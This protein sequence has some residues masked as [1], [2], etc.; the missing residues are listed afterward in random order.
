MK[1]YAAVV[2]SSEYFYLSVGMFLNVFG[3]FG[4]FNCKYYD[5]MSLCFLFP[6]IQYYFHLYKMLDARRSVRSNHPTSKQGK[7]LKPKHSH[8]RVFA[9]P[10]DLDSLVSPSICPF[11]ALVRGEE[12]DCLEI[13]D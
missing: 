8:F 2:V 10:A 3:K 6:Y 7:R 11:K 12:K 1:L 4:L 5:K 13:Q 9:F